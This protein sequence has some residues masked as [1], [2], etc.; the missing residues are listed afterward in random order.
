MFET[1]ELTGRVEDTRIFDFGRAAFGQ[2]EIELDGDRFAGAVEVVIGELAIE[3]RIVHLPGS[4]ITFQLEVI[5]SRPGKHCYRFHIPE[6]ISPYSGFPK[7][8]APA[9]ADGEVAPFRYVEISHYF[10]PATIRRKAFFGEWDDRAADFESSDERLNRVW[11]FCKYSIKATSCFG[12]YIDGQRERLPYEGDM[13]INALGHYACDANFQLAEATLEHFFEYGELTWPTEWLLLTPRLVRD[14]WLY[15]G[16]MAAVRRWL[17]RLPE[18]LLPELADADGLRRENSRIRDIVDWPECERDDYE[19]GEVN[20]VPNCCYLDALRMM[21]ELSGD[22]AYTAHAAATAAAMRR[23]FN[24]AGRFVDSPGSEHTS[25]HSAVFALLTDLTTPEEIASHLALVEDKGMACGVYGAQF[26]LE[27]VYRY[28]LA[29]H[30]LKLL[31]GSTMRGWLHML[32]QGATITMESWDVALKLNLDFNHAWATAPANIIPHWL[33]G[34]RPTAP[35]FARFEI[36]PQPGP[37]E[38]FRLRHPTV[39][40]PVELEYDSGHCSVT[41][42]PGT[43]GRL[44]DGRELAPGKHDFELSERCS[45]PAMH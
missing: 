42:P 30:G 19:F 2:L 15:S 26:L 24:R 37:L 45:T 3:G 28:R 7:C 22:P 44:P 1:E 38:F 5:R 9:D 33:C 39:H 13:Y 10:G 35:G 36:D 43:V 8:P 32:E 23:R 11:D 21:G 4:W 27:C 16:D 18:K 29:R 14:Y 12:K 25:L 17:P 20:L 34:V 31:T 40:G 41:V 6:H